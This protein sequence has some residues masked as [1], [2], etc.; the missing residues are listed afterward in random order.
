MKSGDNKDAIEQHTQALMSAAQ[1][2][3]EHAQANNQH[4]A[5]T[6][7]DAKS[8]DVVDAEFEEVK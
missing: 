1:K 4:Q 7:N 5:E 8:D 6:Q 2:L 3:M